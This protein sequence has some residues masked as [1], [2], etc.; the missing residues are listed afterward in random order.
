MEA[1]RAEHAVAMQA[2]IGVQANS[3]VSNQT[4][5]PIPVQTSFSVRT[6]QTACV[7]TAIVPVPLVQLIIQ[8]ENY[9]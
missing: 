1:V 8:T 2:F 6:L 3:S 7:S 9:V 4:V 5:A